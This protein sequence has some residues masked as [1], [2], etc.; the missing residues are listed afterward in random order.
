MSSTTLAHTNRKTH[1]MS[2]STPTQNSW[3]QQT[4]HQFFTA[5][6]WE[7][8][9]SEVQEL[10]LTALQGSDAPLS[11]TLTVSQFFSA[12]AWDGNAIAITPAPATSTTSSNEDFTLEDF[13]DLF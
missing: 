5:F 6:N 1:G 13:S 2:G 12:I 8:H 7:G 3:L 10:K 4:V 9:S 11:L